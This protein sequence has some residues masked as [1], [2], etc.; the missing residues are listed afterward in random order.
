MMES[1]QQVLKQQ[2][3]ANEQQAAA[4]CTMPMVLPCEMK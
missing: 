3:T 2:Q 1:Y 4:N